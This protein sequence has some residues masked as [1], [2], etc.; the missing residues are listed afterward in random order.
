VPSIEPSPRPG[1]RLRPSGRPRAGLVT[2][3]LVVLGI[4]TAIVGCSS[5]SLPGRSPP[6]VATPAPA[7]APTPAA[8]PATPPQAAP[9]V[10]AAPG[11]ARNWNEYKVR[12]AQRMV[13]AN[14]NGT[15][16]GKPQDVLLA[17]PVLEIE[18]NADGSIRSIDVMRRPG[19]A[20]ETLQLAIDAVRRSAPFGDVRNLP[21]PWKF[22]EVFLFNDDRKFKPRTLDE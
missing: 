2:P 11:A 3:A 7:P 5:I 8:R 4:G 19:Q 17:I 1:H 20:P 15:Y 22:S 12:A 21:R 16:L 13:A 10:A 14:P 9:P 18:L 6:P